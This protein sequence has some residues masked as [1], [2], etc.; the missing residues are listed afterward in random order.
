MVLSKLAT[1][2]RDYKRLYLDVSRAFFYAKA[3]RPVFVRIP[4]EDYEPGDE[5]TR[6]RL[7]MSMYGTRDA[8]V[9]W[10][11]GCVEAL[12]KFGMRRGAASP[13]FFSHGA[14]DLSVVVH[15]DD[16][17]AVGPA[18]SVATLQVHLKGSYQV[19]SEVMGSGDNEA[20][21]LRILNRVVS[22]SSSGV[23]VEADPRHC[24]IIVREL[25][26]VGQR[27]SKVRGNKDEANKVSTNTQGQPRRR[28]RWW[29]Q[30]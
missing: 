10:H 6:G 18:R 23:C 9:N 28:R 3:E 22:F 16:F 15:G 11:N 24:E 20:K 8:A 21:E 7:L 14:L 2:G 27:S 29:R 1:K 5:G 30:C 12:E 26:L 13:C 25:G 17:V 19:K 4:D